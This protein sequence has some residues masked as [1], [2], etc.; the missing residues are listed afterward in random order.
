MVTLIAF[1]LLR[2]WKELG[3]PDQLEYM[4]AG[5]WFVVMFIG[6]IIFGA[7]GG[8]AASLRDDKLK[9]KLK[10]EEGQQ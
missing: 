6:Q 3:H 8:V 2:L 9:G 4:I 7:I 5:G 10:G 1:I